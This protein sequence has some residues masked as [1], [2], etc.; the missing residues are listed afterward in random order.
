MFIIRI[1]LYLGTD[2]GLVKSSK[3]LPKAEIALNGDMNFGGVQ[4]QGAGFNGNIRQVYM[5][6]RYVRVSI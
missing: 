3:P 1:A 6:G 2:V 4:D 5:C